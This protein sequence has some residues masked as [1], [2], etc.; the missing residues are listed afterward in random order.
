M[1]PT[2]LHDSQLQKAGYTAS[3]FRDA[4]FQAFQLSAPYFYANGSDDSRESPTAGE[5]EWEECS[6]FFTLEEL[7]KGGFTWEELRRAKFS[8]RELREAGVPSKRSRT[9]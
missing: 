2:D 7:F 6:A 8:E 9:E 5:L 1:S 3:D 4:G